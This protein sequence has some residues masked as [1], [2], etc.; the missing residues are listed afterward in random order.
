MAT[1]DLAYPGAAIDAIL[2]TAYFLQEAGYIFQGSASEYSG[3]P[4][5]RVWLIAPAGFTGLGLSSAV[6]QGSIGICLYNGTAWVGK[7]INVV[8]LDSGP[9]RNSQNGVTSGGVAAT[10][11]EIAGGIM[12]TF[13]SLLFDDET[14]AGDLRTKLSYAVKFSVSD[15]YETVTHLNILA[16]TTSKAGL[17]SAEDKAKVD[18]FLANLRS[19]TF[20]DTTASADQGT[21]ITETLKATIGGVQEVIDSITLLAATSSKAGLLS[22]SD[23]AYIDALPATLTNLSNS[24]SGA[25]ALMQSMMGYY[26]CDTAAGTAAKTVAATGYSLTNG[27]CI[28]IKMT[29]ADTANNVT[30]NINYTGAKALFY[31]GTQASATNTWEAGE[32]L[33]VYYDGTQYQCASGGGGKAEKI[34]YDNPQGGLDAENV[35]EALDDISEKF[36]SF[37]NDSSHVISGRYIGTYGV[38]VQSDNWLITYQIP[39]NSLKGGS[40]FHFYAEHKAAHD[41]LNYAL[42]TGESLSTYINGS[43]YQVL[44]ADDAGWKTVNVDE[45]LSLYPTAVYIRFTLNINRQW[46]PFFTKSMKGVQDDIIN[47]REGIDAIEIKETAG[48][49][50]IIISGYS[51]QSNSSTYSKSDVWQVLVFDISEDCESIEIQSNTGGSLIAFMKSYNTPT[52]TGDSVGVYATGYNNTINQ[53]ANTTKRYNIPD[54]CHYVLFTRRTSNDTLY[55]V[56]IKFGYSVQTAFDGITNNVSIPYKFQLVGAGDTY[57]SFSKV[58]S[59]GKIYS[60]SLDKNYWDCSSIGNDYLLFRIDYNGKWIENKTKGVAQIPMKQ[61][62][63]VYATGNNTLSIGWRA[64]VGQTMNITVRDVTNEFNKEIQDIFFTDDATQVSAMCKV[65]KSQLVRYSIYSDGSG[66]IKFY[67]MAKQSNTYLVDSI[68]FS[69]TGYYTGEYMPTEDVFMVAHSTKK[70]G[71]NPLLRVYE[72][73]ENIKNATLPC[74]FVADTDNIITLLSSTDQDA[75]PYDNRVLNHCKIIQVDDNLWYMWYMGFG[76]GSLPYICMAISNDGLNWTRGL[77]SGTSPVIAN[78][79]VILKPAND[80]VPGLSFHYQSVNEFDVVIINDINYPFRMVCNIRNATTNAV[81]GENM[82]MMKSADGVTWIPMKQIIKYPHDTYPRIMN[83]G[84]LIKI[85]IRM[86]DYNVQEND[87]RYV[88]VMYCD[89]KGNVIVSPSG[90]FG[91]GLYNTGAVRISNYRDLLVPTHYYP[92]TQ[93]DALESY[94]VEN[95]NIVKYCPS[96]G[97]EN[98]KFQSDN[99]GWGWVSGVIGIGTKQYII[100]EQATVK[101]SSTATQSDFRACPIEWVTHQTY[102]GGTN[103]A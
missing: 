59:E 40:V 83:Y 100:Y 19:L 45:L 102:N 77:P 97:L 13:A 81:T 41:M 25:L 16:A 32:V 87:Q 98:L 33:E 103:S 70:S 61:L 1:Y 90:L 10:L 42:Y 5:K 93:M 78:T 89:I 56:A 72:Y 66:F 6:P 51:L 37:E 64:N 36:K 22:A 11:D 8:T 73:G 39:I 91:Y 43:G 34:K 7:V 46:Q 31:D 84:D 26:V 52:R 30:L 71:F 96:Y 101:H 9:T 47:L 38:S 21:K 74:Q 35:Q 54:D 57:K 82:W 94:I 48:N 2:N 67:S 55:P 95:D 14:A 24:I 28:R 75:T 99:D 69:N 62:Y 27:G 44:S 12:A 76:T 4:S 17:M 68:Q 15:V 92:T 29:N 58:L 20:D 60:I 65:E 88:G 63:Y 53:A 50:N 86:W 3:T 49:A 79:N 85:Y 23:K 80:I 18:S